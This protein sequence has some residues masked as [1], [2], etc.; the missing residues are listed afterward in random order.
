MTAE[1]ENTAAADTAKNTENQKAADANAS[2]LPEKLDDVE[3]SHF[4]G[5]TLP[6]GFNL[7]QHYV[8]K[9]FPIVDNFKKTPEGVVQWEASHDLYIFTI[10]KT[11]TTGEGANKVSKRVPHVIVANAVPSLENTASTEAGQKFIAEAV[12]ASFERK[13]RS[14]FG[15]VD[16]LAL[17]KMRE[18]KLPY[19][20]EEFMASGRGESQETGVYKEY[21][22]KMQKVLAEKNLSISVNG[23]KDCLMSAAVA[24]AN[25][26]KVPQTVWQKLLS[27]AINMAKRDGKPATVF[28]HWLATRDQASSDVA[29][30]A[31]DLNF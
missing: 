17:D 25:Y 6:D 29:I 5:S 24:Q 30:S 21:A 3:N 4:T 27:G 9:G 18:I 2:K 1:T 31:D 23:L 28:E 10:G 12:L 19:S 22:K 11:V 7:L 14:T 16:G 20:A 15:K 26:P 8:T 13:V